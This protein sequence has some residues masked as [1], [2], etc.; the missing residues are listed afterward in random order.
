MVSLPD[1]RPAVHLP[2]PPPPED[3]RVAPHH[4]QVSQEKEKNPPSPENFTL[5]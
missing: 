1:V 3:R 4:P 5:L 2:G